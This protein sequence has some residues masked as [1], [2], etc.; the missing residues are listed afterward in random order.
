MRP[1]PSRRRRVGEAREREPASGSTQRNVPLRPKW[2]NVRGELRGARPV[3]ATWRRA[4][5][6]RGPSRSAP[7]GRSPAARRRV[8]GTAR[9]AASSSVSRAIRAGCCSS[10]ASAS[11][12]RE[13]PRRAGAGGAAELGDVPP[14]VL[15]VGRRTASPPARATSSPRPRSRS[16]SRCAACPARAIGAPASNGSPERVREQVANGRAGRAGG[17]VEVDDSL[18]RGDEHRD[19]GRELRHRRPREIAALVAARR[20]DGAGDRKPRRA[21]T[22]TRPP[23]A[24]PPRW[25][26]TR[27]MERQRIS[28][29]AAF[30]ARVGYSRAVRVGTGSGSRAPR[31]SC[32]GDADPPA[33]AYEQAQVCLSIVE[34]ALAEAGA[35][36]DDVVRTRIY[37]TDA[38]SSTTSAA[39]TATRSQP[40]GRDDGDRDAVLDPRWLVEI[41][42]E[43]VI[44]PA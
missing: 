5:R 35:S 17:L 6:G 23:G 34:R 2:P 36:L 4:A 29:G 32:P 18:L 44:L 25:A 28:S 27:R 1:S 16:S 11:R 9:V 38:A 41:E 39:R 26:D 30:E 7:A 12:S 14:H 20:L 8:P 40:H 13:R 10:C 19:R 43:A 42:A 3:R 22:A 33:G 31:R 15:E 24:A 21:R 37:V